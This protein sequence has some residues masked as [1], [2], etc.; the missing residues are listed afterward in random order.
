MKR[1]LVF[2]LIVTILV[3]LPYLGLAQTPGPKIVLLP[4]GLGN[5]INNIKNTFIDNILWTIAWS[6]TIIMFTLAGFKYL[7]AKGNPQQIDEANKAVV[8]GMIGVI[9]IVLAW[10]ATKIVKQILGIPQY[11]E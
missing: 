8:W 6:F 7:T 5:L 11:N 2:L 3:V 1:K 10:S 4:G 9:V